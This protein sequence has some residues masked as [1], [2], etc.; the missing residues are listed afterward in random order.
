M[1]VSLLLGSPPTVHVFPVPGAV[2]QVSGS[3]AATEYRYVLDSPVIERG[4][5]GRE[6]YLELTRHLAGS[7]V[8][9]RA[10]VWSV[11]RSKRQSWLDECDVVLRGG[12]ENEVTPA[13]KAELESA[14]FTVRTVQVEVAAPPATTVV[15]SA[16]GNLVALAA[17]A[18]A[19]IS[20]PGVSNAVATASGTAGGVVTRFGSAAASATVSGASDSYIGSDGTW[21]SLET[22]GDWATWGSW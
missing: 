2:V 20:G 5:V 21:G 16:A 19:T 18:T 15:G 17:G 6:P 13:Q 11:V 4:L 14:G 10:G 8:V 3:V 22:W 1:A 7:T 9:K 12:Y